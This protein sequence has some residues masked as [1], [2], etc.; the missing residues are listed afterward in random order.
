MLQA[1]SNLEPARIG[2]G[3]GM[4]VDEAALAVRPFG[5]I[6]GG[7]ARPYAGLGLGLSIV[8]KL[9]ELHGGRLTIAS[10][11][12]TATRVSLHFPARLATSHSEMAANRKLVPEPAGCIGLDTFLTELGVAQRELA[13]GADAISARYGATPNAA[14]EVRSTRGL[15]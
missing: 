9:I 8:S 4:T 10:A 1:I 6:A 15:Q 11:P 12:H 3:I 5:Q 2:W 14:E 13:D 7:L